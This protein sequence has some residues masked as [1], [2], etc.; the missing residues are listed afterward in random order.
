MSG[1]AAL[2]G[3]FMVVLVFS[4]K[5][6]G[7][8]EAGSPQ[9]G[10]FE[11]GAGGM[12]LGGASYGARDARLTTGSGGSFV[13]FSTSTE[14]SPATGVELHMGGRATRTIDAELVGTYASGVLKTRIAGDVEVGG[15]FTASEPVEQFTLEGAAVIR[16]SRWQ[17]GARGWPFASAGIG[18]ARQVHDGNT[19]VETGHTY[20]LGGGVKFLVLSRGESAKLKQVGLRADA[21][22]YLRSGGIALDGRAHVVPRVSA[23]VF[24]R[25]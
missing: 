6:V 10:R 12:W 8:Q 13:L 25:F 20:H 4:G 16:L 3:I 19:L 23:S 1:R 15:D 11:L 18:Y 24:G 14:M 5:A 22:A 21:R 17:F 2:A 7:A 9:R